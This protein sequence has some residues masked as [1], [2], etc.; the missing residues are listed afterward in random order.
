MKAAR[1]RPGRKA[2]IAKLFPP[3]PQLGDEYQAAALPQGKPFSIYDLE[4][5]ARD[6]SPLIRQAV[7]DVRSAQGRAA[8]QA[9]LYPNP[10]RAGYEGDAISQG[11]TAGQGKGGFIDQTIKTGGKLQQAKAAAQV[12]VANAQVALRKAQSDLASK[13]R[14]AY[15]ST[16]KLL[17]K[18]FASPTLW[19]NSPTRPTTSR[20]T[21]SKVD[22]QP[23]TSPC[24]FG[25]WFINRGRRWFKLVIDTFRLGNN[26]PRH[27][28][29]PGMLPYAAARRRS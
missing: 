2:A 4:Q 5:M 18:T 11:L 25:F 6:Y 27:S 23:P 21:W 26:W 13:V 22:R 29:C 12:G 1:T 8:I 20:S 7:A 14:G 17:R 15:F 19:R 9:G 10:N 16:L 3:L 28:A 24:N